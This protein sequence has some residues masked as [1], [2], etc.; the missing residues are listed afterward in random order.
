[1]TGNN[2]LVLI[3]SIYTEGKAPIP[4]TYSYADKTFTGRQTNEA[5]TK[6]TLSE[7]DIRKLVC[8][9]SKETLTDTKKDL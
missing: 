5:A 3:L 9:T 8:I 4:L 1:M 7:Y 2:A 6:L